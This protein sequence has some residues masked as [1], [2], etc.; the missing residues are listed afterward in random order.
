MMNAP[1]A[2]ITVEAASSEQLKN[3]AESELSQLCFQ[4]EEGAELK[5]LRAIEDIVADLLRGC[6][7]LTRSAGSEIGKRKM[8]QDMELEFSACF[9]EEDETTS[10][11][12]EK[13]R[14]LQIQERI[15]KEY[16]EVTN[17]QVTA[18]FG[19]A[20]LTYDPSTITGFSSQVD[21]FDLITLMPLVSIP[22]CHST[23]SVPG[24]LTDRCNVGGRSGCPTP[25]QAPGPGHLQPKVVCSG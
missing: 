23:G 10:G 19:T 15:T 7:H 17:L 14:R 9:A 20:S 16:P 8:R 4:S 6:A 22:L 12:L 1:T 2:C 21:P 25:D 3:H 5:N 18:E 13:S 11:L 24:R